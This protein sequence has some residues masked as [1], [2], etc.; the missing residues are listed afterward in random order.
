[1]PNSSAT[2]GYLLPGSTTPVQDDPFE[3]LLGG[4]I[5]GISGIAR[6][7]V[8]PRWQPTPPAMPSIATNWCAFGITEIDAD[9]SAATTHIPDGDGVDEVVR[10]DT[11]RI[12]ASFY[13]PSAYGLAAQV[14]DGL[15]V[16]QNFDAIRMAGIALLECDRIRTASDLLNERFVRRVD[17]DILLRRAVVR[18]YPILNLLSAQGAFALDRGVVQPFI[19]T[20]T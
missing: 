11:V 8:R 10:H 20:E 17:L 5:A 15:W 14:R 1:M 9:W 16:P 19:V 2:G 3:D 18:T 6:G 7:M 4:L 12:L 13:G